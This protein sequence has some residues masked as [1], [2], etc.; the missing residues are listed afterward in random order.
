MGKD[1]FLPGEKMGLDPQYIIEDSVR[2]CLWSLSLTSFT[3]EIHIWTCR[4]YKDV[5]VLAL[6]FIE[7]IFLT[8]E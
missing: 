4:S 6:L 2:H 3:T 5:D 7:T 8:P 1:I